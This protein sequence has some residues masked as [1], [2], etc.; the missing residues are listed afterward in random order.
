LKGPTGGMAWLAT[1]PSPDDVPM[2]VAFGD[3]NPDSLYVTAS[4]GNLYRTKNSGLSGATRFA[5]DAA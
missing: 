1:H 3:A 4:D 5:M 2:R